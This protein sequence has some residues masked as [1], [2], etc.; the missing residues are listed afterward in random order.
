MS[1]LSITCKLVS[2]HTFAFE[3]SISTDLTSSSK[4][5]DTTKKEET[6]IGKFRLYR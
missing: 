5:N 3:R 1:I 2:F 4:L 6:G